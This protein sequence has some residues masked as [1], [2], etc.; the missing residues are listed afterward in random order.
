MRFPTPSLQE[1]DYAGMRVALCQIETKRWDL[2]SN[3][4]RSLA[5][6]KTAHEKGAELAVTPECVIHGYAE[7]N[8]ADDHARLRKVA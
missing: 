3:F 8:S 4:E 5:A 7:A 1:A 2:D 6:L